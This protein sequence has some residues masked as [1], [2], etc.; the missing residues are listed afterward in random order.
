MGD[1]GAISASGNLNV[2]NTRFKENIGM[3]K[4]GAI[5]SGGTLNI[6]VAVFEGNI[7]E[8]GGAIL[9]SGKQNDI[10]H[11]Q[12]KDNRVYSLNGTGRGGV[13]FV[14][15]GIKA[16]VNYC[17]FIKNMVN[18]GSAFYILENAVVNLQNNY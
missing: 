18:E 13:F 15:N 9:I 3:E 12:F 14:S 5:C 17:N 2:G 1:G 6:S 8:T 11:C 10:R 4:G 16:N 7:A